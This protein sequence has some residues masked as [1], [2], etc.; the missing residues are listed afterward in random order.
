M[1]VFILVFLF[2]AAV[3]LTAS[4]PP[5]IV[6]RID[7]SPIVV[8]LPNRTL[9]AWI[10]KAAGDHDQIFEILSTDNGRTW[11]TPRS[12][13]VFPDKAGTFGGPEPL[14]DRHGDT[15]LF[16]VRMSKYSLG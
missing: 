12:I 15:H 10:V 16:L 9:G 11:T 13:Y 2:F 3:S 7:E 6:T 1:L 5:Q 4:S 8:R 14:V